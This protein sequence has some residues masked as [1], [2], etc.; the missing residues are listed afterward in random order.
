MIFQHLMAEPI[1]LYTGDTRNDILVESMNCLSTQVVAGTCV[2]ITNCQYFQY[3][4]TYIP[5][6]QIWGMVK[7]L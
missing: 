3:K 4:I 2:H 1:Y 6:P 5:F 7:C